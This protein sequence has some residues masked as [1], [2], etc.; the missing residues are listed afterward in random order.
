[1]QQMIEELNE[2][3]KVG[4]NYFFFSFKSTDLTTIIYQVDE[5]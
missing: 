4:S 5:K 1:M 2:Q 3:P